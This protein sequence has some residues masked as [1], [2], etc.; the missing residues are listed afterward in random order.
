MEPNGEA[1][2]TRRSGRARKPNARYA[3][4]S[5]DDELNSA[6][7]IKTNRK[8]PSLEPQNSEKLVKP[9]NSDGSP[10]VKGSPAAEEEKT[11]TQP[12][13]NAKRKAAPEVFDVPVNVLEASLGPWQENELAEWPSWTDLESDPVSFNRI[14]KLLGIQE[15][16]VRE[17][18]SVDEESLL[19]LPEPLYGLVFLYQVMDEEEEDLEPDEEF[20]LWFANQTTNNACATVALFNI[21]MNAEGLPLDTNLS[22]FKEESKPLSPP[23]RGHLLSNSSWIRVA[24]NHFARRL[25]LLNAALALENKVEDSKKKRAKTAARRTK[26]GQEI[27]DAYH[28]VA[29][30]P[31]HRD[32]SVWELDGLK[33]HPRFVGR[34]EEGAHWTSAAQP[35]IQEKMMEYEAGQLA[36][37]LL[38]LCGERRAALRRQLA[39]NIQCTKLLD[40]AFGKESAWLEEETSSPSSHDHISNFNAKSKLDE[41]QLSVNEA[42]L[43]IKSSSHVRRLQERIQAGSMEMAEALLFKTEL[44]QKQEQLRSQYY[45]EIASGPDGDEG[46]HSRDEDTGRRKDHTPAIHE[47]VTKL[48]ERGVLRELHEQVKRSGS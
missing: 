46:G 21:I 17:V 31:D 34:F 30:V 16:K 39:V 12:R 38:A 19:L 45:T 43:L 9:S 44:R 24:H 40:D 4:V 35:V 18:L 23:L 5:S 11:T 36:F 47:W 8:R 22:K 14:L 33:F 20:G 6:V 26:K 13:R 15:A 41:F 27:E 28:F 7:S 48:A 3:D 29:Y 2:T 37:S 25:D 1:T 42:E 32:R 10:M